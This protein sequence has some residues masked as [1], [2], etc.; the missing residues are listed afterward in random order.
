MSKTRTSLDLS[1]PP[2][3][4]S[5]PAYYWLYDSLRQA[6]L[7]NRL[8]PGGKLPA[9]RDLA[10]QYGL[11]RGTVVY[12]FDQLKSE[13][14]LEGSI[15]SGTYVNKVLPED[16]LELDASRHGK[17]LDKSK[18]KRVVSNYAKRVRMFSGYEVRASRAFRA[19][20]PA[21][22]LFPV[23]LWSKIMARRLRNASSYL[24]MGCEPLG[25]LALR[26]ATAEY[27]AVS[28]GVKCKTEQIAI[29][30]G[31]QEAL[32]LSARLL[33]NAGEKIS[34]ED[35]G[36]IGASNVF[37]S[38][39]ARVCRIAM[40]D[41]G[42]QLPH[43]RMKDSRLI[44]VTPAHQFP[45][46]VTMSLARRLELLYWAYQNNAL[47]FED[48]YDSEFRF[49]G[50]PIPALQGL[51]SNNIVIYAGT[52]S[53]VLFPS[54]RLGYM[55]IPTDLLDR[56][57]ATISVTSRHAPLLQQAA[58]CDF[59]TEGHFGR[60]IRRMREIYAERLTTLLEGSRKRL[61]GLLEISSVEAGLQ[62][63]GWLSNGI[64]AETA[65]AAAAV[66]NVE[67]TPLNR[68]ARQPV[69]RQGLQLGFAAHDP[70]EIRNGI[71]EL[72]IA[73]ESLSRKTNR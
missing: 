61:T 62:T 39:G 47:I 46:G 38:M 55:V 4:T 35:P 45:L 23:E 7:S 64:D 6:I 12:A 26:E 65:A 50:R 40:D 52:F 54:L 36:Y 49:S 18:R 71:Q 8:R 20:L 43:C 25:F 1:L 66:R 9:T 44:Y 37:E 19:N 58:L 5:V 60:H 63:A 13:G 17:T 33:V 30:S 11:S 48:D 41:Q 51:D 14:Y 21:L 56:F 69:K 24:L 2:R 15:G 68:Y 10:R 27:L 31:V 59:I 28:R 67:V 42:M 32:D 73:L 22:D 57:S 72:A 53:K 34:M 16:L 70:R 3:D 29:V